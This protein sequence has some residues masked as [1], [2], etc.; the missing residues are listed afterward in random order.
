M[1][2]RVRRMKRILAALV[3]LLV[4]TGYVI[5]ALSTTARAASDQEYFDAARLLGKYSLVEGDGGGFRFRDPLRRAELAKLLV[6][7]L[8]M[9][10]QIAQFEGRSDFSDTEGHWAQPI[11]SLAKQLGVMNGYPEGDFRPDDYVNYAEVITALSR[12]VGLEPSTAPW[13]ATYLIPAREAGITTPELLQGKQMTAPALRGDVFIML[14]RTL[15]D[16]KNYAGQTLLQRYIDQTPPT[17]KFDPQPKEIAASSITVSGVAR[18]AVTVTINGEPVTVKNNVFRHEVKLD[19]LGP[20]TIRVQAFDEASN[21]AEDVVHVTRVVGNA[22]SITVTGASSVPAGQSIPL[23]VTLRDASGEEITDKVQLEVDVPGD[24]GKF[25]KATGRFTA[26]N[27]VMSGTVTFRAGTAQTTKTLA[28]VAGS[29]DRLAIGPAEI[30]LTGG[31]KTTFIVTGLDAAGNPVSTPAVTWSA[32]AGEISAAGEFEAPA[33]LT[34]PITIT[35]TGGGKTATAKVLP[36]NH[37]VGRVELTEPSVVLRANGRSELSLTATVLDAQGAVV[38]DYTGTLS[39]SSSAPGVASPVQLAVPVNS[40]KALIPVRAGTVPGTANITVSTNLGVNAA[41]AVRVDPQQFQR[42]IL[43]GIPQAS[44]TGTGAGAEFLGTVEAVAVDQDGYPMLSPLSQA[45]LVQLT[46]T[47]ASAATFVEA[48]PDRAT[49]QADIALGPIDAST[50]TVR[51]R[52]PIR[53]SPGSGTIYVTGTVQPAS[54]SWVQV[55]AGALSSGQAGSAVGVR[56]EPIVD[57]IAG[58]TQQVFVNI[59]DANGFRVTQPS[60]L[61]GL[62]VTLRDQNGVV[63]A[64]A[65]GPIPAAGS[66]QA[67]GVVRFEVT[68]YSAGTYTY[69]ALLSPTGTSASANGIVRA[70]SIGRLALKATPEAPKA[71][72]T[73]QVVLRAEL[74]D[75]NGNRIETGTYEVSFTK[76]A[77][78]GATQ[79][80]TPK[81]VRSAGGVAQ[82]TLTAGRVVATDTYQATVTVG[83]TTLTQAINITTTGLPH[84]LAIRYGDNDGN[85]TANSTNDHLG[86]VGRPVH[87]TV[88]VRDEAGNIVT[89]DGART[90]TLTLRNMNGGAAY[91]YTATTVQGKA[92]F[93]NVTRDAAGQ[94][95]LMAETPNLIKGLSAGY[96]G[97][98]TLPDLVFQ[99]VQSI[100]IRISADLTILKADNGNSYALVSAQLRDVNGN[101]TTNQTGAPLTVNLTTGLTAPYVYGYFSQTDTR[102]AG[103]TPTRTVVIPPGASASSTVKF[104][105]GTTHGSVTITGATVDGANHSITIT[106]TSIGSLHHYEIAPIEDTVLETYVGVDSALTGQTVI[107]TA[108]DSNGHR[109]SDYGNNGEQIRLS[110]SDDA[111]IVAYY[112][113]NLRAW[114]TL[115]QV[116]GNGT[117]NYVNELAVPAFRGQAMFRVRATTPGTKVYTAVHP[118]NDSS[119]NV[120][121]TGWFKAEGPDELVIEWPGTPTYS[122]GSS[123]V[124]FTVRVVD[125]HGN[126]LT[127]ASGQVTVSS[128]NDAAGALLNTTAELQ[129]GVATFIFKPAVALSGGPQVTTLR[130]TSPNLR[131]SDGSELQADEAT[132]TTNP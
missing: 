4:A 110:T 121:R 68:Q 75:N 49:N 99:P 52:T 77:N 40:G 123:E 57:G 101:V 82:V 69:T 33:N 22:A 122:A 100:G 12:L 98:L 113:W 16:V 127:T 55:S 66:P 62:T 11:I 111:R 118:G 37:R 78:N 96:G 103:Q 107:V 9:Q 80:F 28:V 120:T 56:F 13:P 108:K 26:G 86:K 92:E 51:A 65:E 125:Q 42:V 1:F 90:V 54:M 81:V 95:A 109:I 23:T 15:V 74:Q 10:G 71:D 14:K 79:P 129:N 48:N 114:R 94:Y 31:Q 73:S 47:P 67:H 43:T 38:T 39:I 89:N 2:R 5:F 102:G 104:F 126:H 36:P 60:A 18:D 7:S 32:T 53:Y 45:V 41:R 6:F 119:R 61:Q 44:T 64:P 8:G 30:T 115:D 87:L 35:A 76:T 21:L 83:S 19:R 128:S 130:A 29:L 88:E 105:S 34:S 84:H 58:T 70:S 116:P 131:R 50:G 20:N 106:N 25:D 17:V 27:R 24:L 85:G 46:A 63:W 124:T 72:G 117:D 97:P 132:V 112:D 59:V 3:A 93:A 91:T